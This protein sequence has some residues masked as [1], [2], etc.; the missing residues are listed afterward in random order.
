VGVTEEGIDAAAIGFRVVFQIDDAGVGRLLS[1]SPQDGD[2]TAL[3]VDFEN[4]DGV[5]LLLMQPF[6]SARESH[7]VVVGRVLG[8]LED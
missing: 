1:E 6:R 5:D 2:F 8:T 7:L 4:I 3:C